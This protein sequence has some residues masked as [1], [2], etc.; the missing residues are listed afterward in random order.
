M[1]YN[2]DPYIQCAVAVEFLYEI[3][4]TAGTTG[5]PILKMC[6]TTGLHLAVLAVP[7][8]TLRVIVQD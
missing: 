2:S 8:L 1:R 5:I 6:V 4:G 7:T 3:Y